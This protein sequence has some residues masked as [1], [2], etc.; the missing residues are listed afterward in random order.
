M[1]K[2][3]RTGLRYGRL[4][5]IKFFEG[6]KKSSWLCRCDCGVEK[7][8]L[9]SNLGRKTNSCGCYN[10]ECISA[11]AKKNTWSKKH[12]LAYKPVYSIWRGMRDRCNNPNVLSYHN[13]GGRGI[14][15]DP[16]WD[17]FENFLADMGIQEA[18]LSLD[19]IDNNADYSKAN[20]RWATKIEQCNNTRRNLIITHNGKTQS[21]TLW[22]R[23]SGV[24]VR[25][26]SLRHKL[27]WT[28]DKL[29][30]KENHQGD[31]LRADPTPHQSSLRFA[32]GSTAVSDHVGESS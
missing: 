28:G 23:E 1:K 16:N 6:A 31:N 21:A 19:R 12:G 10:K 5:A 17:N 3:D 13:Y 22:A 2:V 26:L 20:C 18:G 24:P 7:V 9:T 29:F 25:R 4:I 11:M 8:F 32:V 14:G 15:Y 30:S 27:G